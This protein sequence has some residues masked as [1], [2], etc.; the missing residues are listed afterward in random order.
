MR[1]LTAAAASLCLATVLAV[2]SQDATA[3]GGR[4]IRAQVSRRLGIASTVDPRADSQ[5]N[6]IRFFS[7]NAKDGPPPVRAAMIADEENAQN[8]L[9]ER[10]GLMF[11]A[12]SYEPIAFQLAETTAEAAAMGRFLVVQVDA[13]LARAGYGDPATKNFVFY[14]GT[15]F[16]GGSATTGTGMVWFA[17]GGKY[18]AVVHELFHTFGLVPNCAPH[19]QGF[20]VLD[21]ANDL[22]RSED[23]PPASGSSGA[24]IQIDANHDDYFDPTGRAIGD[25]PASLNLANSPWVT[26]GVFPILHIDVT[27]SGF[28]QVGG[29]GICSGTCDLPKAVG[30]TYLLVPQ[31]HANWRFTGWAGACNGTAECAVTMDD[32]R[33]VRATFVVDVAK[34]TVRIVGRGRVNGLVRG[35]CSHTCSRAVR[36]GTTV[37]LSAVPAHAWRFAGWSGCASPCTFHGARKTVTA[38]FVHTP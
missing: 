16:P 25:C 2:V 29:V 19:A 8:F 31:P 38:R 24:G 23:D 36:V 21:D 32:A 5:A 18:P 22:M 4:T 1:I 14:G 20:H 27:G 28:V 13:E 11:R 17:N 6:S 35:G 12:R 30:T 3:G 9:F 10:T 37:R 34:V 7:V 26:R 15:G 33:S